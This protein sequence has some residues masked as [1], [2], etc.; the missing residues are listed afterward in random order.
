MKIRPSLCLLR[1][2]KQRLNYFNSNR[3]K[4]NRIKEQ[5]QIIAASWIHPGN[6]PRIILQV[7]IWLYWEVGGVMS[8]Y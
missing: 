7:M 2:F 8:E 1:D 3:E 6:E 5:I 4:I